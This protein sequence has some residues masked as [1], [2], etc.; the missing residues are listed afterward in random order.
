M[1]N[2]HEH[3]T[4]VRFTTLLLQPTQND[5]RQ[6]IT[7]Y[8]QIY[9]SVH[10]P[11]TCW[12]NDRGHKRS[13]LMDLQFHPPPLPSKW[14]KSNNNAKVR[15]QVF[16]WYLPPCSEWVTLI[17]LFSLYIET[18]ILP[19]WI[20]CRVAEPQLHCGVES[21]KNLLVHSHWHCSVGEEWGTISQSAAICNLHETFIFLHHCALSSSVINGPITFFMR[22]KYLQPI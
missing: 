1:E 20:H 13:R 21:H 12:L 18:Q 17:Y 5:I 16:R 6:I 4:L 11:L 7:V 10:F 9:P 19:D 15:G 22:I 2:Y 14:A 8:M 3:E